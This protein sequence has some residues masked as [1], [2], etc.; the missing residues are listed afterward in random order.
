MERNEGTSLKLLPLGIIKGAIHEAADSEVGVAA[1]TRRM[2]K[3]KVQR[4][5]HSGQHSGAQQIGQLGLPGCGAIAHDEPH[6]CEPAPVRKHSGKKLLREPDGGHIFESDDHFARSRQRVGM[7]QYNHNRKG[8]AHPV[9]LRR[10]RVPQ[11]TTPDS[12]PDIVETNRCGRF[13]RRELR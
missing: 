4:K 12:S 11:H 8:R 5:H 3:Y 7:S 2:A 9:Q 10:L 6:H 1:G 13:A